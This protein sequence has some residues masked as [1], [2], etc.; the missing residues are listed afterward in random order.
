LSS[1]EEDGQ[2]GYRLAMRA[3][4]SPYDLGVSQDVELR[5]VPTGDF[6]VYLIQLR[7]QRLSG[8]ANTWVRINRG[9]LDDIRKQFLVWRTLAPESKQ[10]YIEEAESSFA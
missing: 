7:I 5:A 6:G 9:F 4:L 2:H 8:Q 10:E 3:W 1:F